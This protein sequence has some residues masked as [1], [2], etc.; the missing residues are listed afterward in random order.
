MKDLYAS[1]KGK[2]SLS[3]EL[4]SMKADNEHLIQL[5]KGTCEYADCED[6]EILRAAKT[7][8]LNGVQG[9]QTAFQA[10]RRARG[11]SADS[12]ALKSKLNNDWIPTEAVRALA[13]IRD[14]F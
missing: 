2:G 10:N 1:R 11:A 12:T 13:Q 9:Y 5:L 4:D 14:K 8:S 6:N 7:S 3:I